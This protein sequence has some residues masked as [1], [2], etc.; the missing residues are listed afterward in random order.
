LRSSRCC[1]AVRRSRPP[2][3]GPGTSRGRR[4]QSKAMELDL[5]CRACARGQAPWSAI[6]CSAAAGE[7]EA[8]AELLARTAL[9]P[10]LVSSLAAAPPRRPRWPLL[11]RASRRRPRKPWPLLHPAG[12]SRP[13]TPWKLLLRPRLQRGH[14]RCCFPQAPAPVP[15]PERINSSPPA[16]SSP[17]VDHGE[18]AFN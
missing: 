13:C 14:P 10:F 7:R 4:C 2:E 15:V 6:P 17:P 12:C 11:R 1:P 16:S 9:Q 5:S 3:S 8:E 18:V